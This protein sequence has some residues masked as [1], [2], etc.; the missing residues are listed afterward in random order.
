MSSEE[1]E[2]LHSFL[3]LYVD[4]EL[5]PEDEQRVAALLEESADA[6]AIVREQQEVK[7]LIAGLPRPMAP[8]RLHGRVLAALDEVDAGVTPTD[9]AAT[10]TSDGELRPRRS[11]GR[12]AA[13]ARG[14]LIMAPAAAAALA[15]FIVARGGPAGF[16]QHP[17]STAATNLAMAERLERPSSAEPSPEPGLES[18]VAVAQAPELADAAAGASAPLVDIDRL[19]QFPIQVAGASRLPGDIA[20]VSAANAEPSRATVSY[21]NRRTGTRFVDEQRPADEALSS[22]RRVEVDGRTYHLARDRYGRAVLQFEHG[23]VHHTLKQVGARPRHGALRVVPVG[24]GHSDFRQLHAL[25]EAVVDLPV[26]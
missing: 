20:L 13:F 25:A 11:G 5:A 21:V 1:H 16:A 18:A 14:G 15:L 4:H 22:G 6:R 9:E 3:Q 17:G 19:A 10:P 24:L 8:P 23:G 7:A 26:R 2:T 12:F